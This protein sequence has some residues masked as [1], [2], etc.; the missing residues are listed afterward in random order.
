MTGLGKSSPTMAHNCEGC[1]Y[2][3]QH[4]D[5]STKK[6]SSCLQPPRTGPLKSLWDPRHPFAW[7][8]LLLRHRWQFSRYCF[9]DFVCH[10][11]DT[12]ACFQ[13]FHK[14][15]KTKGCKLCHLHS[16]NGDEYKNA[17][18]THYCQTHGIH[19]KFT[20]A[21]TS[22][23]NSKAEHKHLTILTMTRSILH[24]QE[25]SYNLWAE[26]ASTAIHVLVRCPTKSLDNGSPYELWH[27]KNPSIRYLRVFRCLAYAH[28]PQ[29][30]RHK[31]DP[32]G[33]RCISIGYADNAHGYK[34]FG[35]I[36][37][38]FFLSCYV[39]FAKSKLHQQ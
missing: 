13:S 6:F 21:Y 10:K 31:L 5:P 37:W 22:Q 28:V 25:L 23:Q 1:I 7:R 24:H 17:Q 15:A 34:L 4:H 14:Q 36:T 27:K 20:R 35:P 2:G 16:D 8:K 11:D 38:K 18:F 26:A 3:K 32:H 33:T 19:Q 29:V 30:Q 9:I 39:I 12:F